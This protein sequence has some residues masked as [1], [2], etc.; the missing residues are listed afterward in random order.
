MR[1]HCRK[2]LNF[3]TNKIWQG[4]IQPAAELYSLDE[5]DEVAIIDFDNWHRSGPG[6]EG[7]LLRQ[8]L[9]E[10][11]FDPEELLARGGKKFVTLL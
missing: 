4:R 11:R 7:F 1:V 8:G 2:H 3:C 5:N 6:I 10:D 9:I